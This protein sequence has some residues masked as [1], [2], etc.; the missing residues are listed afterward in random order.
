MPSSTLQPP[1]RN[2]ALLC[3]SGH[4]SLRLSLISITDNPQHSTLTVTHSRDISFKKFFYLASRNSERVMAGAYSHTGCAEQLLGSPLEVCFAQYWSS[5]GDSSV[6]VR[7]AFAG[8][9]VGANCVTLLPGE[10]WSK[11][12]LYKGPVLSQSSP[13]AS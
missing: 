4:F 10:G 9:A 3:L 8:D 6:E 11:V 12:S 7:A 5:L 1:A 2:P 13:R